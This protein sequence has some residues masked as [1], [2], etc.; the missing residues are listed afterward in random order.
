MIKNQFTA[1]KGG[2]L[3]YNLIVSLL[4]LKWRS[5][6][7]QKFDRLYAIINAFSANQAHRGYRENPSSIHSDNPRNILEFFPIGTFVALPTFSLG[8]KGF[9]H[10]LCLPFFPS[11][12]FSTISLSIFDSD[13]CI[14]FSAKIK[15]FLLELPACKCTNPF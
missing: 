1:Y 6:L 2:T 9:A 7:W 5:M 11:S 13:W 14:S 8:I 4:L 15:S 12:N 3:K 10:S